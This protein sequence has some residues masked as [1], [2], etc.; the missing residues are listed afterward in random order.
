MSR[1]CWLPPDI[2]SAIAFPLHNCVFPLPAGKLNGLWSIHQCFSSSL[3]PL[4]VLSWLG[5]FWLH[6]TT[7]RP[8]INQCLFFSS[9]TFDF[10]RKEGF[11]SS[12]TKTKTYML[13]FRLLY[14][15]RGSIHELSWGRVGLEVLP[16]AEGAVAC[17]VMSVEPRS[18]QVA[19]L[20]YDVVSKLLGEGEG[21]VVGGRVEEERKENIWVG[22]GHCC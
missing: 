11:F 9:T 15:R 17:R 13:G 19:E 3:K 22:A 21:E 10:P 20:V 14:H 1:G 6:K 16:E 8:S 12:H 18:C 7:A 4:V 2:Y 5:F